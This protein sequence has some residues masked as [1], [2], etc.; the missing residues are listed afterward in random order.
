MKKILLL[1]L[2][3]FSQLAFGQGNS[4]QYNSTTKTTTQSTGVVP[5]AKVWSATDSAN[6]K[7]PIY[8]FETGRV[9]FKNLATSTDTA[10]YNKV[11]VLSGDS[12]RQMSRSYFG[13][14]GSSTIDTT[15]VGR[16]EQG[17]GTAPIFMYFNGT[18]WV[19]NDTSY[20]PRSGADNITGN[21]KSNQSYFEVGLASGNNNI[22]FSDGSYTNVNATS[23]DGTINSSVNAISSSLGSFELGITNG[24]NSGYSRR[25]YISGSNTT[26]PDLAFKFDKGISWYN[27]DYSAQMETSQNLIPSLKKVKQL[28]SDSVGTAQTTSLSDGQIWIGDGTNT[29]F[30]RTLSGDVT[31][32]NL[33][34]T[35]IDTNIWAK[36]TIDLFIVAGQSNAQGNG[37]N[38]ASGSPI[39]TANYALQYYS[40]A[41]SVCNDPVGN[42]VN[43]SAWPAFAQTYYKLTGKAICIVPSATGATSQ[44]CA[45]DLGGGNWDTCGV[46]VDSTIARTSRAILALQAAGWTV[47]VKGVLWCQGEYDAAGINNALITQANYIAAFTKMRRRFRNS[48]GKLPFYIFQTGTRTTQSDVGY[49]SIRQAQINATNID[50]LTKVVFYEAT[51]FAKRGLLVDDVHY[52]GIGYNEMGRVGA[53]NIVGGFKTVQ[54]MGDRKNLFQKSAYLNYS[55]LGFNTSKVATTLHLNKTI[56]DTVPTSLYSTTSDP[57]MVSANSYQQML[58]YIASSGTT[59]RFIIKGVSA[60]GTV[61]SPTLVGTGRYAL[62]IAGSAYDGTTTLNSG[63]F[64]F[65][66][67]GTPAIGSIPM[68]F[69]IETGTSSRTERMRIKSSG[70]VGIGTS[71]PVYALDV[72]NSAFSTIRGWNSSSASSVSGA[73]IVAQSPFP[74]A[75]YHRMGVVAFGGFDGTNSAASA[76]IEAYS[77]ESHTFGSALGSQ[78]QFR[79]TPNGSATVATQMTL[80]QN[81]SLGIGTATPQSKLDVEGGVAIGATYSGTTAAPTNGAIIEGRLGIGTNNPSSALHVVGRTTLVGG[82][83]LNYVYKNAN[84]TITT[85]EYIILAEAGI[86]GTLPNG[87]GLNSFIFS[88]T[89]QDPISSTTLQTTSGQVFG[90]VTGTPTSITIPGG[91]TRKVI[92]N[93]V[94]WSVIGN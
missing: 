46:L 25:I 52:T 21:L 6:T 83:T 50:S 70:E 71:S 56:T 18:A 7:S 87:S 15:K 64:N 89:N 43:A 12:L 28:I 16:I 68:A 34:V 85:D 26:T 54:S 33:G 22:Q 37:S 1:S 48:L 72:R 76:R 38:S 36:K 67:E 41:L 58:G 9:K 20:I 29:A 79:V 30:P 31:V 5:K 92:W 69:T 51:S 42:A 80:D 65:I 10:I 91:A 93:S 47:N 63:T 59:D 45:A 81:G 55:N 8:K 11:L 57:F 86:T 77:T 49:E 84:Y 32:D 4:P 3:I 82:I 40:H 75:T 13:G 24:T 19:R 73:F 27:G 44:T 78:L 14:G 17:R 62:T 60:G 53:E 66:T 74:T 35:T 90:N 2:V 61:M 94:D 88:I 23:L 39:N